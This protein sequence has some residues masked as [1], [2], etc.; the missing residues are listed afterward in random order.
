MHLAAQSN[1]FGTVRG[2]ADDREVGLG[3]QQRA[4]AAR[5]ISWSSAMSTRIGG[6]VP[7]A[8]LTR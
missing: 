7:V 3:A 4:E 6:P 8:S 5:T 2:A 1:R